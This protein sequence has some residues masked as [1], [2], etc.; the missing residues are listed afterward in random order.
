MQELKPFKS[1]PLNQN[2]TN[3]DIVQKAQEALDKLFIEHEELRANMTITT[4][5]HALRTWFLALV[6]FL[7]DEEKAAYSLGRM[8]LPFMSSLLLHRPVRKIR[9]MI[10]LIKHHPRDIC[11]YLEDPW[12]E[13]E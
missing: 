5:M 10:Y 3:Q 12:N 4:Q 1:A 7:D 2:P 13:R 6:Y 9:K 11:K 8:Y